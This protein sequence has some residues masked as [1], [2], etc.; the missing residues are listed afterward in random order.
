MTG[1]IEKGGFLGAL[2]QQHEKYII[3]DPTSSTSPKL[4]S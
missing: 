1:L 4:A 2:L 3:D